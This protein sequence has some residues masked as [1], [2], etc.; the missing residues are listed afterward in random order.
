MDG[1]R[2]RARH[3][4]TWLGT[5]EADGDQ[6]DVVIG[7]AVHQPVDQLVAE[8]WQWQVGEVGQRPLEPGDAG[9]QIGVAPLDEPVGV[10]QHRGPVVEGD[11]GLR[12][13][14]GVVD[15]EDHLRAPGSQIADG[16]LDVDQQRR[17]V[18]GVRPAQASD[19][20]QLAVPVLLEPGDNSRGQGTWLQ[21][22]LSTRWLSL[23]F[24]GLMVAVAGELI[25]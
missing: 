11:H 16:S 18:A 9:V 12:A 17:W 13:G 22:R 10:Q 20:P 1:Q 23:L 25:L 8:R 19:V 24:A 15:S 6:R 5:G 14:G 2:F 21:Q 3:A 7:T 4:G